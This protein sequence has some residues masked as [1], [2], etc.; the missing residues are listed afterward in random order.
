MKLAIIGC[1]G[2]V[3]NE[4]LNVLKE[5]AVPVKELI[6]VASKKYWQKENSKLRKLP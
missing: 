3:E 1:T 6:L 4:V 2:L 5:F